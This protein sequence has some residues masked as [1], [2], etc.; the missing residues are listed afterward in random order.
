MRVTGI[1]LKLSIGGSLRLSV[2][3]RLYA[4]SI[5]LESC[6]WRNSPDYPAAAFWNLS[7]KTG[8]GYDRSY[9]LV[10]EDGYS[11]EAARQAF[12]SFVKAASYCV[13]RNSRTPRPNLRRSSVRR[14]TPSA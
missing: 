13:E 10:D 6:L 12:G 11:A 4:S 2:S 1:S 5:T 9:D 14:V 8:Y 7:P 3:G